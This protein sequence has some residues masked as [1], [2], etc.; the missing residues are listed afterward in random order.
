MSTTKLLCQVL[1]L[2]TRQ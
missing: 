1:I 2:E